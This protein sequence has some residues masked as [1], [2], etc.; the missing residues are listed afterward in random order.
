[1]SKSHERR[2]ISEPVQ[3][4][5]DRDERATLDHLSEHLE[6]SKSDV[7]RRALAALERETLS[8]DAHPALRLIA[9][10]G[11]DEERDAGATYDPAVEHDRFLADINDAPYPRPKRRR[12][13]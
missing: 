4:Y 3:V 10:V 12:G 13:S 9:M 8:P 1:M 7:I 6:L 11:A 5:L 2:R